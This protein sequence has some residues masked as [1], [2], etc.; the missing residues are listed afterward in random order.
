MREGPDLHSSFVFRYAVLNEVLY[1]I[2]NEVLYL[3]TNT[4]IA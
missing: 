1:L 3:I 4:H 2:T